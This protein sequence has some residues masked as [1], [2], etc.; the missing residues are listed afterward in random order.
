[1]RVMNM[2]LDVAGINLEANVTP[3]D[4]EILKKLE[5]EAEDQERKQK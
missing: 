2:L 1:M 3:E 4:R 5:A